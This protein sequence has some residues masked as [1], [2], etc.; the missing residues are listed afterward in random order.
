MASLQTQL[1]DATVRHSIDL[2]RYSNGAV[3]RI[4]A[5][6]NRVDADLADQLSRAMERLPAS[7][8]TVD[9]LDALLKDVRQL[10][11]DAYRQVS[12]ALAVELRD[13]A[14][15]E[16]G[17]QHQLFDSLGIEYSTRGVTAGQ[18]YAGAMAR[19]FQ[20]RLLKEWETGLEA[21]RAQRL[22]DA[23]RMGYVEGQTN[24]Q[25][26]QRIRGTRAA[27]Y[28]DGLL[29]IDRRH[30]E[31]LVRTAVGH[32]AGFAR[33]RWYETNDDIIGALAWVSTL[34]SRTSHM[35]RLRDGLRFHPETHKPMG[36]AVP[37]GAGPGR[38][39]WQCRSTSVPVLKGMEDEP[40][41]GTRAAK[42]YKDS[43]RGKGAQVR[44]TTTYADWLQRQPAT[45]QDDILGPT[46]AALFRRGGLE[47][48]GFYNDRGKYLTLDQLRSK[49]AAAFKR[50]GVE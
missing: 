6:L 8:F 46:R 29:E 4:L 21:N 31:S 42:D 2:V 16:I 34:D 38:L 43:A 40:L 17:Y 26:V 49:D 1:Y 9:R 22:R 15:Y 30:A 13:L 50:A 23:V 25:I 7:A 10:N 39:H 45:I 19:P 48:E 32:T 24:Q 20:G 11:A 35:C 3:R 47:L 44:A 28:A 27:G 14:A 36:H 12:G 33:D 37:W 41:F 5:L 18:A